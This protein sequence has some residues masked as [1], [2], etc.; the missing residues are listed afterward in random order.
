VVIL[1]YEI[2]TIG[3]QHSTDI[4]LKKNHFCPTRLLLLF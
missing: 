1:S 3:I 2:T 4:L